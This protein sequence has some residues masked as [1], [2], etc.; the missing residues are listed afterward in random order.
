[1]KR[2]ILFIGALLIAQIPLQNCTR[3]DTSERSFTT[4]AEWVQDA[5]S[6]IDSISVQDLGELFESGKMFVLIDVR[7]RDEHD[8]GYIPGSVLIPR[9][10]IEFRITSDSYW[11]EEGLYTPQSDEVLI[12]YCRS[13]NRSALATDALRKMGYKNVYSL[14]GG[15]NTWKEN[16]PDL[17]EININPVDPSDIGPVVSEESG[18]SC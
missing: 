11:E 16:F 4:S 15:F 14:T 5:K 13:G 1:M 8:A 18:G 9:G 17:V 12:L 10:L 7:E 3:Q 6:R 2:R